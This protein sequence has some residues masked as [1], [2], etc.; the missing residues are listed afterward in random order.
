MA[1][2]NDLILALRECAEAELNRPLTADERKELIEVF[3]R[4]SIT[5]AELRAKKT[6]QEFCEGKTQLLN[7]SVTASANTNRKMNDL[8]NVL[9]N[10]KK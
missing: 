4:N 5:S 8:I 10:W 3:N 6:I 2:D 1:T 9:K 7:E